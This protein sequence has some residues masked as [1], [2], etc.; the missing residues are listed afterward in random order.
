MKIGPTPINPR[1]DSLKAVAPLTIRTDVKIYHDKVR[2]RYES[3]EYHAP[4]YLSD[5]GRYLEKIDVITTTSAES[6]PSSSLKMHEYAHAYLGRFTKELRGYVKL[7][8]KIKER[9][10]LEAKLAPI[11]DGLKKE[12]QELEKRFDWALHNHVHNINEK[13]ARVIQYTAN[14]GYMA[15]FDYNRP[16]EEFEKNHRPDPYHELTPILGIDGTLSFIRN[17]MR[18]MY[19]TGNKIHVS[20]EVE[21][22]KQALEAIPTFLD[23]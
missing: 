16:E 8:K 6:E 10:E 4:Y 3:G 12:V 19:T 9:P 11:A 5:I 17:L 1:L 20:E 23:L 13:T 14:V 18:E 22:Y 15:G 21:K 2:G 7:V